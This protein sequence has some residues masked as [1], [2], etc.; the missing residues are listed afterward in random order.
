M[1][2]RAADDAILSIFSVL[3]SC[4]VLVLKRRSI[5][6]SRPTYRVSVKPQSQQT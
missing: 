3:Y 6:D 1:I 4:A 5:P 2:E